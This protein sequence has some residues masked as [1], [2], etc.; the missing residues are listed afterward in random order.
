MEAEADYSTNYV[1]NGGW[2]DEKNDLDQGGVPCEALLSPSSDSEAV[3]PLGVNGK[4]QLTDNLQ[5]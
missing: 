3:Q 5:G 2:N 4:S 1:K